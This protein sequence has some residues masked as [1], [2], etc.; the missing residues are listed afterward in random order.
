LHHIKYEFKHVVS[1]G[2]W[3]TWYYDAEFV[4]V[5]KD[6]ACNSSRSRQD[7]ENSVHFT[8]FFILRYEFSSCEVVSIKRY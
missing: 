5:T 1:G 8:I 3:Y 7:S 2:T 4:G 6:N